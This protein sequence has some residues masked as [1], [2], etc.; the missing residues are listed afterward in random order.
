M[1]DELRYRKQLEEEKQMNEKK[2]K[3]KIKK[4]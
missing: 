4:K 2:G 1:K 3:D